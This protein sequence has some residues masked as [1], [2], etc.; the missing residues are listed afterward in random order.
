[1]T[2]YQPALAL[3]LILLPAVA[4]AQRAVD[5]QVGR[6]TVDGP[7]LTLY[8]AALWRNLWGPLGYSLRGYALVD[9]DSLGRSLYG[10]GPEITLLRGSRNAGGLTAYGVG[11]VSL[12]WRAGGS[13]D[14]VA[15]W[16]A[17]LGLEYNVRSLLGVTLEVRRTAEDG[18]F[19]GFWDLKEGDRRGWLLSLGF[20][21][22][23]GGGQRRPVPSH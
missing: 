8:S 16:D 20:S 4:Q 11:G 17:G 22:R 18:G 7:D 6:W 14:I 23:W 10:F 3:A 15:L 19:R 1:M 21:I 12:A 13:S 5:V 2:R 9:R